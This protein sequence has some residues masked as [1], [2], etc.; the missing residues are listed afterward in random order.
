MA[1]ILSK[2]TKLENKLTLAVQNEMAKVHT[3]STD[4]L[5]QIT[6]WFSSKFSSKSK[7]GRNNQTRQNRKRI[8]KKYTKR[9]KKKIYRKKTQKHVKMKR[10]KYTKKH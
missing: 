1:D 5:K 7:G 6:S 3:K 2:I 9:Y 8:Q 10:H 4:T